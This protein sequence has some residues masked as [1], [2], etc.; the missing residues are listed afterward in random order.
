LSQCFVKS[1]PKFFF[2]IHHYVCRYGI[3]TYWT[4]S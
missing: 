2:E 4:I 1:F 3:A